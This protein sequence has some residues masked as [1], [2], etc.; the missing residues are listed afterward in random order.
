MQ[1]WRVS[2]SRGEE[3]KFISHLDL[4]R[5][6]ERALRRAGVPLAYSQGFSPHPR[7]SLAAPL[8]LGITS[9][10]E[11]M[12]LFLTRPVSDRY[13]VGAL[14][15][16]L[17]RGIDI[18]GARPVAPAAPSLPSQVRFTEYRVEVVTDKSSQEV[19]M[20][21][22]SL[23]SAQSLPWQHSRDTGIRHYDLRALIQDLWLMEKDLLGMRLRS[24]SSGSGRPEQVVA[25]LGLPL[26]PRSIH[27]TGLILAPREE[28]ARGGHPA[29]VA[30]PGRRW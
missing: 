23:L 28:R 13:L 27:R 29:R 10:A 5:L 22:G 1:R 21:L 11:L 3:V 4:M 6:W 18:L 20:A 26:P 24:D 25:A 19:E 16:Q 15:P 8:A 30:G 7:L 12:D 17:P 9:Q 2:F 14:R